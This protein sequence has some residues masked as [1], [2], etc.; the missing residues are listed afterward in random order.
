VQLTSKI[1]WGTIG[2]T[3]VSFDLTITSGVPPLLH[4]VAT[5]QNMIIGS[6]LEM[7]IVSREN[8]GV[9]HI[10]LT[11]PNKLVGALDLGI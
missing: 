3:K 2:G 8:N 4:N 7:A 6:I 1:K 10:V 11:T 5:K 9:S